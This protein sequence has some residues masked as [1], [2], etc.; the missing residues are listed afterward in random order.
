MAV[1]PKRNE[2]MVDIRE[3]IMLNGAYSFTE[4]RKKHPDCTETQFWRAVKSVRDS[5]E[6]A[7]L[8][9][10]GALRLAQQK[11]RTHSDMENLKGKIKSHLPAAPSPAVI[12]ADQEETTKAFDFMRYFGEIL[13]DA[14]MLRDSAVTKADDGT[15][16]LRNP[17]MMDKSVQRR[18]A[19]VETYLH[20]ME[21]VY[22]LEKIQELYQIVLSA[23]GRADPATQQMILAELRKA[24]NMN[25]LTVAAKIV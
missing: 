11:I 4:V 8:G 1:Y 22:N 13:A 15:E 24:N 6:K 2:L 21:T 23:V 5:I 12:A 9:D 16:K 19:I 25:G 10:A 14:K 17:M 20:S 7:A 3:H 18:L